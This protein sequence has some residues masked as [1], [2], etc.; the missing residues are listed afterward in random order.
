V[1]AW[2][3]K[4]MSADVSAMTT[5]SGSLIAAEASHQVIRSLGEVRC[6]AEGRDRVVVPH[7][8]GAERVH[9][10]ILGTVGPQDRKWSAILG[11][12]EGLTGFD[13]SKDLSCVLVEFPRCRFHVIYCTTCSTL[14]HPV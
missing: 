2:L 3:K 11:H 13:P 7:G 8:V 5:G 10:G 14:R 6:T 1:S 9:R 4:A 12:G